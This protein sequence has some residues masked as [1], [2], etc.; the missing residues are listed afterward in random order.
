MSFELRSA[1]DRGRTQLGW[2]DS[3]HGFSFG[4][5]SDPEHESFSVLRVFNDDCVAPGMGFG[6][7]SHSNMEIISYVLDGALRHEDST[8]N[9]EILPAG[10]IQR[11]SAG[12]G[13][14]HAEF[15][16]SDEQ[17]VHFLQ[18]WLLPELLGMVPEY[19]QLETSSKQRSG[20]WL[21]VVTPHGRGETMSINQDAS[22]WLSGLSV[23]QSAIHSIEDGR[24]AYLFLATGSVAVDN[25]LLGPGDALEITGE[26]ILTV[27]GRGDA[28]LVLFDLP[29]IV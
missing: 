21:K 12:T 9:I 1:K 20:R 18:I 4:Q 29:D 7:H 6:Q 16:A 8:G 10:G 17:P 15:N 2:L 28:E 19:E 25:M 22:M 13:I 23:G 24:V 5:Y 14:R 3:R 11:M 27:E 26:S